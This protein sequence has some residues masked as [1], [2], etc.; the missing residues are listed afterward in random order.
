MGRPLLL[1]AVFWVADCPSLAGRAPPCSALPSVVVGPYIGLL[2][3]PGT[4]YS[5]GISNCWL[6]AFTVRVTHS[7]T[8]AGLTTDYSRGQAPLPCPHVLTLGVPTLGKTHGATQYIIHL[9]PTLIGVTSPLKSGPI[10]TL[11]GGAFGP[12]GPDS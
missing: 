11:R 1:L 10:I 7:P 12:H 6:C 3:F 4:H 2:H 8:M 9:R 5:I